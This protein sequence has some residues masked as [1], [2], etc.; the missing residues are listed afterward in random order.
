MLQFEN[1][2]TRSLYEGLSGCLHGPSMNS[3]CE[4]CKG[5]DLFAETRHVANELAKVVRDE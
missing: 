3:S 5:D 2:P 4:A 1:N